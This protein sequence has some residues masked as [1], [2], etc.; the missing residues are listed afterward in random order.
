MDYAFSALTIKSVDEEKR[1]IRGWATT[2]AP[3]RIG[4]IVEPHGLKYA[5]QIP[6]FLYHDSRQG[7]G[8]AELGRPTKDGVPFVARIPRVVEPGRLKDLVDEA[9]QRVKYKLIAAVSIGFKEVSGKV[10]QLKGG[11]LRFL[12][13]EVLEL[14]LVPIPMNAAATIDSVKAVYK[15]FDARQRRAALGHDARTSQDGSNPA[16]ATAQRPKGT[17][18]RT[19]QELQMRR[20]EVAERMKELWSGCGSDRSQ[21]QAEEVKE[22][23]SLKKELGELDA[24]IDDERSIARATL[25]AVEVPARTITSQA[26]GS[27][28]RAGLPAEPKHKEDP[29]RKGVAFA[30]FVRLMYHAKG[31]PFIAMQLA[32]K[33]KF[34]FGLDPRV[35][36]II[37]TAVEAGSVGGSSTGG[38]WGMELVGDETGAVADFAEYLRPQTI[39]GRFGTG[40]I[41]SLNEVPFRTPLLSMTAGL[42]GHWVGEGKAKPM[43]KGAF[44]RTT[45][46]PLKCA[47]L[48][49]VTKELLMDSSPKA[50]VMLR[51]ELGASLIQVK[52]VSFIDPTNAGTASVEPP[53]VTYG[54]TPIGATG[55]GDAADVRTDIRALLAAFRAAN[56]P[57]RSGVWIMNSNTAIAL[58][59]MTNALGQPEFGGITMNGGSLQGLPIIVSDYVP[60]DT[61]GHIVVL[62]NAQDVFYADDGGVTVATSEHASLEMDDAP[63]SDSVTPTE[64]TSVSMFQT[65]SVA[66][67]AEQRLNWKRRRD[68]GVQVLSGA[69]WGEA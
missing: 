50:D 9:W 1:E 6:L 7:V 32:E 64:T 17:I 42:T 25:G 48:T 31:M 62:I 18:M 65:N 21:L 11:G 5:K 22:F 27:R 16:G 46:E 39:L 52:D 67:L 38:N 36:L 3:D 35:P 69:N 34:R 37:K 33:S 58:G 28:A 60:A 23:D 68:S 51:N 12:E 53:A 56:N 4:D 14:S 45:L 54:I 61:S 44:A 59:L 29:A 66:F 43:S 49:A 10:E 8:H 26:A 30:Q 57:P 41:P 15:S 40:G 47:A 24:S 63:T 55:T 13:A 2:P 19:L 20:D